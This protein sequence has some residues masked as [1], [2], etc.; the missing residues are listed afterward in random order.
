MFQSQKNYNEAFLGYCNKQN[1]KQ[2]LSAYLSAHNDYILKIR[3]SNCLQ[4]E[5]S[6]NALPLLLEVSGFIAWLI[7]GDILF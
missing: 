3:S 1:S 2:H 6:S 7:T 4:D 5:Y